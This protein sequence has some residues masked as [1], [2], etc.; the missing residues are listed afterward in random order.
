VRSLRYQV[1]IDSINDE[2]HV[3]VAALNVVKSGGRVCD[4]PERIAAVASTKTTVIFKS[5]DMHD[6]SPLAS[7]SITVQAECAVVQI[8]HR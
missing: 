4:K 8:Q 5:L 1:T 2:L 3:T 7:S 6:F